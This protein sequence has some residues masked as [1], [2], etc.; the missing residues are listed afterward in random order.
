MLSPS[1]QQDLATEQ[2][3]FLQNPPNLPHLRFLPCLHPPLPS[4]SLHFHSLTTNPSP[5]LASL[6]HHRMASWAPC[7][8]NL[9]KPCWRTTKSL[10]PPVL[11]SNPSIRFIACCSHSSLGQRCKCS[12]Y[13]CTHIHLCR[14]PLNWYHQFTHR[15]SW[16]PPLPLHRDTAQTTATLGSH[17]HMRTR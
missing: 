3:H 16:H 14:W 15:L 12:R 17:S 4:F 5:A 10:R 6:H 11:K 13:T 2:H 7:R 8:R 9:P 1:N